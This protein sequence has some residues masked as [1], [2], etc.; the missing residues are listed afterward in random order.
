M[1]KYFFS[2]NIL[3]WSVLLDYLFVL[4]KGRGG[5]SASGQKLKTD[6]SVY[7]KALASRSLGPSR[8]VLVV[9]AD[10]DYVNQ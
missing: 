9:C 3:P 10:S 4:L 7:R 6:I 8:N 1:A 2:S 5:S